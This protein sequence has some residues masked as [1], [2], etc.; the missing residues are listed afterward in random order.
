MK[1]KVLR[2]NF[3]TKL[4]NTLKERILQLNQVELAK[5]ID[6]VYSFIEY[7]QRRDI[8]LQTK[9]GVENVMFDTDD[10]VIIMGLKLGYRTSKEQTIRLVGH[11]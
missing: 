5:V 3:K 6:E 8:I 4:Y 2:Y 10:R 9:F 7:F 1:E 11:L